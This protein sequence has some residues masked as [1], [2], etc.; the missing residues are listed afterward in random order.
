[1]TDEEKQRAEIRI[2]QLPVNMNASAKELVK[3]LDVDGDGVID[4]HEFAAAVTS[5]KNER[6]NAKFL[7]KVIF[8]LI[9]FVFC[10]VSAVFGV[11]IAAARIAQDTTIDPATGFVTAKDGNAVMKTSPALTTKK[12]VSI[13]NIPKDEM[14]G[15]KK[16]VLH[17]GAI[18]FHVKG[19]SKGENATVVLVEGGTLTFGNEGLIDTTGDD[20]AILFTNLF[21]DAGSRLLEEE[22]QMEKSDEEFL[23]EEKEA[24]EIQEGEKI[25]EEVEPVEDIPF[26][27]KEGLKPDE[28]DLVLKPTD[29]KDPCLMLGESFTEEEYDDCM[30][31]GMENRME[32]AETTV[33]VEA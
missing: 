13:H 9:G 19:F 27:W 16:I 1:M 15:V 8:G 14:E 2:S 26:K 11:S 3:N 17:D 32:S 33:I 25:D 6:N 30:A 7:T 20:L 5:L 24:D 21:G 4:L 22:E 10:L 12:G 23:K 29:G 28:E 18:S 31:K